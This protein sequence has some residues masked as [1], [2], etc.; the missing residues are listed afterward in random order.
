MKLAT[1]NRDERRVASDA[2]KGPSRAGIS[3]HPSHATRHTSAFTLA[4]V[5]AAML[6]L[7][8]VIPVAVE[9]LHT[10][11]LAGEVAARKGVAARI[12]DRVLNESLVTT[13][14]TGGMQSGTVSE[15]PLDFKWT[16]TTQTWPQGPAQTL[17]PQSGQPVPMQMLSVKVDYPAQGREYSVTLNTLANFPNQVGTT[18]TS[19]R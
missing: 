9:A 6:F 8:I 11:S 1:Q 2:E 12:A 4:E 13:N 7:A 17:T 15:G 19:M 16:L 18:T 10:S 3:R 14:W 5:L